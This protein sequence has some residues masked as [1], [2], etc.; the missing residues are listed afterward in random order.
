[1]DNV[2]IKI[3]F[4]ENNTE[5]QVPFYATNGSAGMDLKACLNESITLKPLERALI[6]TGIAISLPGPKY[7]AFIFARSGLASK[8]GITLANC[9]GVVDSDY[10]G[11][12][13]VSLVN[14]SNDEYTIND[15]E[16]IAQLVI[17]EVCKAEFLVVDELDQTDRGSGGFGSTGSF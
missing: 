5:K 2:N 8:K 3:K 1:M 10:T 7:G 4:L 14:I 11:E 6:P 15:G 12:I 17:I 9:V 13:K 16:R